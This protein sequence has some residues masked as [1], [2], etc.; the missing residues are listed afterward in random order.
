MTKWIGAAAFSSLGLFLG[1]VLVEHIDLTHAVGILDLNT[2]L[3]AGS[4]S[5]WFFFAFAEWIEI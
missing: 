4:G 3:I 1:T 5:R 2:E